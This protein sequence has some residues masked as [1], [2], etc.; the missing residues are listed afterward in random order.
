M[1]SVG[2]KRMWWYFLFFFKDWPADYEFDQVSI[3]DS[4]DTFELFFN[5]L[6]KMKFKN[7][8]FAPNNEFRHLTKVTV[9]RQSEVF[10]GFSN[11]SRIVRDH[12]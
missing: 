4:M 7:L 12:H 3:H 1:L 10:L 9:W 8:S 2:D 6:I 5:S 11:S